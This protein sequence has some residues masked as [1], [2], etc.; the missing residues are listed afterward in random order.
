MYILAAQKDKIR[1]EIKDPNGVRGTQQ[2]VHER[3]Q[4]TRENLPHEGEGMILE[5]SEFGF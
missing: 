3:G 2:P 4:Q 5:I 1:L